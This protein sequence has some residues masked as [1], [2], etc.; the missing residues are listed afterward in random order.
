MK[1][2]W[3]ADKLN[4]FLGVEIVHRN[5]NNGVL[6]PNL[7]KIVLFGYID[8]SQYFIKEN[9][10]SL[11]RLYLTVDHRHG[12]WTYIYGPA[13][14]AA[15]RLNASNYIPVQFLTPKRLYPQED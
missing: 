6:T 14:E 10:R 1:F 12:G 7:K 13:E 3:E 2:I 11:P 15:A 8:N 4:Q 9:G 5:E